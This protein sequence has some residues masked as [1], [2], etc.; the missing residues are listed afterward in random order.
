MHKE[1]RSLGYSKYSPQ[2][3]SRGLGR[4]ANC[5]GSI[6]SVRCGHRQGMDQSLAIIIS[7]VLCHTHQRHSELWTNL[8]CLKEKQGVKC[9][10]RLQSG[11]PPPSFP[12]NRLLLH[13]TGLWASE[14]R[15]AWLGRNADRPKD[16]RRGCGVQ[17]SAGGSLCPTR[18]GNEGPLLA[19]G[20]VKHN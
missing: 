1:F 16:R 14:A 19:P 3:R 11:E 20:G 6:K 2:R 10:I 4:L 13:T 9:S 5:P 8:V 18:Y 15:G 17:H 12:G 7:P